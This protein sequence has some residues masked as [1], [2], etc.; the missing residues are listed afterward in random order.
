MRD[1]AAKK[2]TL[3][4]IDFVD[5]TPAPFFAALRRL[6]DGM[7]RRREMCARVAI[8]RGIAAAHV[9]TL[10]AHA[11]MHPR[12]AGFETVFTAF[13]GR[14]YLFDMIF[15]VPTRCFR[16]SDLRDGKVK[17]ILSHWNSAPMPSL[18]PHTPRWEGAGILRTTV[19]QE[20]WPTCVCWKSPSLA[21]SCWG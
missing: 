10:Q 5:V 12:V 17:G 8:L 4:E 19:A 21:S 15:D 20:S 18:Q 1:R 14:L 6:N 7:A 9:S 11:Q 16:H 2:A 13:G 3:I